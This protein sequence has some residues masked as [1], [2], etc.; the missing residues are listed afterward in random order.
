VMGGQPVEWRTQPRP[1]Q[2]RHDQSRLTGRAMEFACFAIA[3][4][5]VAMTAFRTVEEALARPL[6][7]IGAA[8]GSD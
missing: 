3:A 1:T 5:A 6:S 2:H 8:L 4:G 7:Q